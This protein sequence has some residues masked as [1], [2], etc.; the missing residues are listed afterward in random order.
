[1]LKTQYEITSSDKT[2]VFL[3]TP[4]YV[5]SV[6]YLGVLTVL[7]HW[8]ALCIL[9]LDESWLIYPLI[10]PSH[11]WLPPCI[12]SPWMTSATI[13]SSNN[14]ANFGQ[15]YTCILPNKEHYS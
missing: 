7:Y 8:K 6:D 15:I 11:I 5:F 12:T 4:Y 3:N 9:Y 13:L 14:R 1:M 2:V 10:Y